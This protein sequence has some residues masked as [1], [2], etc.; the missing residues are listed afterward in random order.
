MKYIL[1][2][3]LIIAS[4]AIKLATRDDF[5][6]KWKIL[7]GKDTKDSSCDKEQ[8]S[9]EVKTL[10]PG[11][12]DNRRSGLPYVKP[13]ILDS[14]VYGPGPID[15]LY[16]FLEPVVGKAINDKFESYWK[17][18]YGVPTDQNYAD[19]SYE[20]PYTLEN[21]LKVK[22]N[23]VYD[24]KAHTDNTK[25]LKE[26]FPNAD[27]QYH[28]KSISASRLKRIT[29]EWG[30]SVSGDKNY[31]KRI[32]D[33]YDYDGDGR[34]NEYEF[35]EYSIMN[36]KGVQNP[37][38]KYSYQEV[39]KDLIDPIFTF[40]D[41][42]TDATVT[43]QEMFDQLKNL[44]RG[45]VKGYDPYKCHLPSG[46]SPLRTSAFNDFIL[47]FGGPKKAKVTLEEFRI[48]ILVGYLIRN[49]KQDRV[50]T[51]G[52]GGN[53][54]ARWGDNGMKDLECEKILQFATGKK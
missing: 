51:D 34:L 25:A 13:D 4:Q 36:T 7:F 41:C 8:Q 39:F 18:A 9:A 30:W 50:I 46:E 54:T 19:P 17:D 53:K 6:E 37:A 16:D 29:K 24:A 22:S 49:V 48:G 2:I 12:E 21:I 44:Q 14:R 32:I 40:L 43:A 1:I 3:S 38:A 10:T 27:F 11:E 26:Y 31:P 23:G 28:S 47:R 20:D 45:D 33:T 42:D 52:T 15:Y 35:L 5:A